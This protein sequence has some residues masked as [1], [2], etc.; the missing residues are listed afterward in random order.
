MQPSANL[1][2]VMKRASFLLLAIIHMASLAGAQQSGRAAEIQESL[3]TRYRL[4]RVGP[5]VLGIGNSSENSIRHAG[6][7]VLLRKE[8]LFGSLKRNQLISMSITGAQVG[9]L[10]GS[11]EASVPLGV[12]ARFY[13]VAV[14]VSSD[15]VT[16]GLLSTESVT[17]GSQTGQLWASLNFFFDKQLIER[18]DV[19][20]IYPVI[21]EWLL[22]EGSGPALAPAATSAAATPARAAQTTVEPQA[23]S[24]VIEIDLG[25]SRN[26]V[27]S[28]LGQPPRE[29]VHGERTWLEYPGMT[30][31]FDANA[32]TSITSGVPATV[33][34]TSEP[35]GADIQVDGRF[36]GTTP[37]TLNL[38]AGGH[39]V[40]VKQAGFQDWQ[41]ELQIYA[42]SEISLRAV[43]SK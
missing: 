40:A 24:V 3:Q 17:S 4:T 28:K 34:V 13:V 37:S 7:V 36:A 8:G 23:S 42:G 19:S 31:A 11:K 39:K 6:G 9:V 30:I 32:L 35:E 14:S 10:S 16:V 29:I 26:Q 1:R 18:G 15:A 5:R 22:P 2:T 38:P 27:I 20:R 25:M 21:D 33:K 41:R 43:L 12:G